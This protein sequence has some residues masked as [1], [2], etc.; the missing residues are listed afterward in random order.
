MMSNPVTPDPA[1]YKQLVDAAKKASEKAYAPY[2]N[3]FVGAALLTEDGQIYTGCNVENREHGGAICAERTALVK[4]ISEGHRRFQAIAVY[5]KSGEGW[6]CGV[7][8]QFISEFGSE[9]IVIVES[10]GGNLICHPMS[11]L[12]PEM[13]AGA[14]A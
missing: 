8:R 7:C 1:V 10:E 14:T 12:L 13:P 5:C 3:F 4:A 2:S 11:H 6:P 9:I